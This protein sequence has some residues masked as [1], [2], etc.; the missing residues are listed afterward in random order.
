MEEFDKQKTESQEKVSPAPEGVAN[1]GDNCAEQPPCSPVQEETAASSPQMPMDGTAPQQFTVSPPPMSTN[2]R[3]S[4]SPEVKK[5]VRPEEST[6]KAVP[7]HM[8]AARKPMPTNHQGSQSTLLK[9]MAHQ[10]EESSDKP[11]RA[12]TETPSYKPAQI[13]TEKSSYKPAPAKRLQDDRF[14]KAGG[15]SLYQQIRDKFAASKLGAGSAKDK[16]MVILVPIL[17]IIMI[18]MF[19]QVLYKSPGKAKGAAKDG[20]PVVV[21]AN[22]SDEIE[23]EIPEP[24]PA[25][26]RDPLKLPGPDN[27]P[28]PDPNNMDNTQNP[29]QGS[30][31]AEAETTATH[32]GGIVYSEDKPSVVIGNK[33]VYVGSTIN[34]VTILKINRDSVEL[35]KDGET[36]VQTTHD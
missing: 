5:L 7:E 30:A 6:D 29:E 10:C 35:E 14:T 1:P 3:S 13:P 25:V 31:T 15:L 23:W 12:K 11:A 21:T 8:A 17:A 19:R 24:L 28:Q 32:I 18:F 9:R 22:S 20:S 33:I 34:G 2:T 36:W 27:E 16:V 4:Q 26:M